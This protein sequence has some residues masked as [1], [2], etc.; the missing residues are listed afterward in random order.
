MFISNKYTKWYLNIIDSAKNRSLPLGVYT[1]AHHI[2]PKSLGGNNTKSNLVILTAKEHFVCHALL[3]KMVADDHKKKMVYA[4]W[5]MANST[6]KRYK[7]TSRMY[8]VARREFV[9]AQ[10]GHPNYMKFHKPESK[11]RI[12]TTMKQVLSNLTPEEKSDRMKK[13]CSAPST[14]TPERI[15]NMKQGMRGKKKTKTPALLAA[16]EQRRN[17][18]QSQKMKCG[19]SNRGKTWKLVGGKRVWVTKEN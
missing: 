11:N 15:E 9:Q 19:D 6:G 4:F 2:I 3:V 18:S 7:P 17:R 8:E 1:E 10:T 12:S 16:E 5:R 13:S 14:W